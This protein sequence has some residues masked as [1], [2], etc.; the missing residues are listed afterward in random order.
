MKSQDKE[1][2]LELAIMDICEQVAKFGYSM[3]PS[4]SLGMFKEIIEDGSLDYQEAAHNIM[5][6]VRNYINKG[7]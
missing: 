3:K 4:T 6:L 1:K 7:N 5:E 2:Q